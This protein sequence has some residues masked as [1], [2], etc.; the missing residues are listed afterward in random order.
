[1]LRPAA[2]DRV[3]P[4][5]AYD[6]LAR[7]F[8]LR[9]KL[10]GRPE[11]LR[12]LGE[13]L[14]RVLELSGFADGCDEIVPVPSHPWIGM[15]RGFSPALEVARPI[16]R[17]TGLPLRVRR[18]RLRLTSARSSKRLRARERRGRASSAFRAAGSVGARVL[19]VDDVMTT[20]A[21]IEA[22]AHALK[23]AGAS[24]VRAAVW[25]RRL[26][27]PRGVEGLDREK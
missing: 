25:A 6:A 18:L 16:A 23:R 13:Q 9:A 4:A 21:T 22:C 20:G 19:L 7:S 1:V 15:R 17:R 24:E 12:P 8:L 3:R 27:E 11:L 5:V 10:G 26:R 2:V 14:A